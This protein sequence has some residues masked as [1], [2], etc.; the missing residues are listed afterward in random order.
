MVGRGGAPTGGSGGPGIGGSGTATGGVGGR[1]TAGAMAAGGGA[2]GGSRGTG[3]TPNNCNLP[4]VVSFKTDV[5]P[6]LTASC[7]K[8]TGSGCHV[9]DGS[10]TVGSM[11]PDGTM[12]CGATHAYDWITA[13]S[14]ASSCPG[15]PNPKRFEVTIAVIDAANPASCSRSRKMPPPG[16]GTPLTACQEATLQAWINEPLVITLH[17]SDDSS[18]TTPYGMPPFN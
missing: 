15:T 2:A 4:A 1:G 11:C 13:G 16:M 9:V 6:I 14:H 7:G 10:S 3:G 12:K 5:Q 18:L 8:N 17:R